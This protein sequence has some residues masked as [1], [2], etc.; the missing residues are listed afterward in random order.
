MSDFTH[1]SVNV[2]G[3]FVNLSAIQVDVLYISFND[4]AFK[5]FMLMDIHHYIFIWMYQWKVIL[6][7]LSTK[8]LNSNIFP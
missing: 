6:S 7:I 1:R 2:D 8:D 3:Y 5:L 4:V